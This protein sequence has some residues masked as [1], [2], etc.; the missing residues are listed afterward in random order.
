LH[1]Y[2][3]YTTDHEEDAQAFQKLDQFTNIVMSICVNV[4]EA[5]V[6]HIRLYRPVS[7]AT[8]VA[9]IETPIRQDNMGDAASDHHWCIQSLHLVS[10]MHMTGL[11][12]ND[13]LEYMFGEDIPMPEECLAQQGKPAVRPVSNIRKVILVKGAYLHDHPPIRLPSIKTNLRLHNLEIRAR[14]SVPY[15]DIERTTL[16]LMKL[17]AVQANAKNLVDAERKLVPEHGFGIASLGPPKCMLRLEYE[18]WHIKLVMSMSGAEQ[19]V[20]QVCLLF[21]YGG[22]SAD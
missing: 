3:F 2:L 8:A 16:E 11:L 17:A 14:R 13:E 1:R 10:L 6:C 4:D 18:E 7:T 5:G 19:F 15:Q 9:I 21:R 22:K 12:G 20:K